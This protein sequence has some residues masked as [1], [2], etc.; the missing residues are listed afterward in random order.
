[1]DQAKNKTTPQSHPNIA[2]TWTFSK[3][4]KMPKHLLILASMSDNCFFL[5]HNFRLTLFFSSYRFRLLRYPIT[6]VTF[7]YWENW[8]QRKASLPWILPKAPKTS[9]NSITHSNTFLLRCPTVLYGVCVLLHCNVN[10]LNFVYPQVCFWWSEGRMVANLN[11]EDLRPILP[12][13][14]NPK[15]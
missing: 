7:T 8:I 3:V 9:S 11:R 4:T 1:M 14:D 15:R 12:R 10:K 6:R 13:K 2:K 5:N